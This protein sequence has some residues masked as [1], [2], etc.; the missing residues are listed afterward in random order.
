MNLQPGVYPVPNQPPLPQGWQLFTDSFGR[1]FYWNH[2][3]KESSWTAPTVPNVPTAA[4]APRQQPSQPAPQQVNRPASGSFGQ[5]TAATSL[6]PGW[7]K[8]ID[9]Q[10]RVYYI[11][12][13]TQT[14]SWEP[15]Q[16]LQQPPTYSQANAPQMSGPYAAP[17][18]P[19]SGPYASPFY[20]QQPGMAPGS[21]GYPGPY[22]GQP[23]VA[24][25]TQPQIIPQ[26]IPGAAPL[27]QSPPGMSVSPS[28][29]LRP[30]PAPLASS[31]PTW[32]TTKESPRCTRC[33]A[34]FSLLLKRRHHCRCCFRQYCDGCSTK[35]T[36]VPQFGH[37]TPVRVCDPCFRHL[38]KSDN[39]CAS[40]LIPYLAADQPEVERA[41]QEFS[42]LVKSHYHEKEFV[43]ELLQLGCLAPSLE[44]L[45]APSSPTLTAPTRLE[46]L[47]VLE[48]VS[49]EPA[50][51]KSLGD[52]RADVALVAILGSEANAETK[53]A[54]AHVLTELARV[55]EN[56]ARIGTAGALKPLLEILGGSDDK[57]LVRQ[58][59]A[60]VHAIVSGGASSDA[61]RKVAGENVSVLVIHVSNSDPEL[62][63]SII[64]T[65]EQ[66][67]TL[68]AAALHDAGA[69][70]AL[71]GLF[72]DK[73]IANDAGLL[74]QTLHAIVAM[75][76]LREA[77]RTI[78]D[79]PDG[80][81]SLIS[82]MDSSDFDIR[83]QALAII[84]NISKHSEFLGTLNR[85]ILF[86]G[87]L[88]T[89]VGLIATDAATNGG[90]NAA[91]TS[92]A[93]R[94]ALDILSNLVENQTRQLLLDSGAIPAIF[95][96]ITPP[97]NANLTVALGALSKVVLNSDEAA[98]QVLSVGGVGILVDLLSSADA[99]VAK[100]SL[101]CLNHLATSPQVAE[102]L[103]TGKV[104]IDALAALVSS[105]SL[106]VSK[107]ALQLLGTICVTDHCRTAL[108]QTT[109]LPLIRSVLSSPDVESQKL[110]VKL[111]G[112][113]CASDRIDD[114]IRDDL[115][116]AGCIPPIIELLG[117]PDKDTQN[118]A[119]FAIKHVARSYLNREEMI[120]LGALPKLCIQLSGTQD[121]D[122]K[123]RL[124]EVLA[125]FSSDQRS[126]SII[127]ES[128]GIPIFT[129]L[130][131]SD[132][133]SLVLDAIMAISNF[134][135]DD[136]NITDIHRGGGAL[137]LVT[138]L[139][140]PKEN[141]QEAAVL[142]L[143]NLAKN[144]ECRQSLVVPETV[145]PILNLLRKE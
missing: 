32:N 87:G 115:G 96:A 111:I 106:E 61:N 44:V 40:K 22:Y 67:A 104:T 65:L 72:A 103:S 80:L 120:R 56:R 9:A 135:L 121:L 55:D 5:S 125:A 114:V 113:L 133:D 50:V 99:N 4:Y 78:A 47:R 53:A 98:V 62:L 124:G 39:T 52:F 73:S 34:E 132:N 112:Q 26:R 94:I 24:P 51:L 6:P 93:Q 69:V 60:A 27:M 97:N 11:D 30:A 128:A 1:P 66:L 48:L 119:S 37:P 57:P 90:S 118:H 15:P 17:V 142:A 31:K 8:A 42:T 58:A 35:T 3:T 10:G 91:A 143:G 75:S 134:A 23:Q 45:A 29:H 139:S 145:R 86:N 63:A 21:Y 105:G 2:N 12:H 82:L 122:S 109:A 108:Q 136:E 131:F 59:A 123:I 14:T 83:E 130:L 64:G 110:S 117:S 100:M 25:G 19:Q 49:Q 81:A 18:N 101:A 92:D 88:A 36:K 102:A 89:L 85:E 46:L 126:R 107:G 144:Q 79:V 70:Q 20:Q 43:E 127:K 68:E 7:E 33:N 76:R 137:G 74:L 140:S 38:G 54:A 71:L 129:E 138:H 28:A 13:A 16:A 84:Q 141:V 95:K 77:C 116:K 41:V